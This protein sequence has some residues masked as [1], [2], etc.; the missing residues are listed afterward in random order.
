MRRGPAFAPVAALFILAAAA[1]APPSSTAWTADDILLAE[2]AAF[3][4]SPEGE[5]A[6]WVKSRMDE[7]KGERVSNLF[8]SRLAGETAE[9]QLTRGKDRGGRR[10]GRRSPS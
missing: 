1:P 6:V 4:I 7:E 8:L 2:S 9:V 3:A 5:R 10:T